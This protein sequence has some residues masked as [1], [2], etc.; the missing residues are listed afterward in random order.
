MPNLPIS[1]LTA[2]TL[3]V[4]GDELVEL[5]QSGASRKA[6]LKNLARPYGGIV[7]IAYAASVTID[8]STYVYSPFLFKITLTGPLTLNFSNGFDGQV[9]RGILIQDA[10]GNRVWTPGAAINFSDDI[11]SITLSIG[12]NKRDRIGWEWYG[13]KAETTAYNRGYA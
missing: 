10:T 12:A 8:L 3:P 5:S 9:I 1:G 11:A 2:A 4:S 7:L 6:T 13:T